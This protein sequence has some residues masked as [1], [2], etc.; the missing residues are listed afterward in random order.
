MNVK[1]GRAGWLQVFAFVVIAGQLCSVRAAEGLIRRLPPKGGWV[2]YSSEMTLVG[3]KNRRLLG[4]VEVRSVGSDR[5]KGDECRWIEIDHKWESE[6]QQSETSERLLLKLLVRERDFEPGRRAAPTIIRGWI[7]RNSMR[8][9]RLTNTEAG[10]AM[11]LLWTAGKQSKTT[12]HRKT[13]QYGDVKL[14]IESCQQTE[15]DQRPMD[16]FPLS[17]I[18]TRR[19]WSHRTIPTLTA[20]LEM[21]LRFTLKREAIGRVEMRLV[22]RSK[23]RGAKSALPDNR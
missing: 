14:R 7:M 6:D 2:S 12:A 18:G 22:V 1:D 23:G 21:N 20:I 10:E 17:V 3:V 4:N 15:I 11:V 16:A 8:V 5:V 19:T 9:K 13:V